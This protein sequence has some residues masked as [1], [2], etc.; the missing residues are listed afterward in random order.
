MA[1]L[2]PSVRG[3]QVE[4]FSPGDRITCTVAAGQTVRGGRLV[5]LTANRTVQEAGAGSLRVAGVAMY[6]GNAGDKISVACEGVWMLLAAGAIV[7]GDVLIAGAAG[8]VVAAGA[9]PDARTVIGRAFEAISNAA[10][11]P[12]KL[13]S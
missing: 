9:A 7:A 3:G 12:C 1:T 11:G 5:E 10:T 6:D 4:K 2:I 13:R 8:T